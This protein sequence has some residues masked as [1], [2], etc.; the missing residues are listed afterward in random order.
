MNELNER[1]V[2]KEAKGFILWKQEKNI[3]AAG[4]YTQ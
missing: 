4:H 1:E 3:S 2:A